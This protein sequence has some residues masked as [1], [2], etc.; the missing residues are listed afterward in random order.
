VEF[1]EVVQLLL[2][3]SERHR[4]A[5]RAVEEFCRWVDWQG[6]SV[7]GIPRS[8][9]ETSFWEQSIVLRSEVPPWRPHVATSLRF[10]VRDD[11]DGPSGTYHLLSGPGG[12]MIGERV[13]LDGE[14]PFE[15]I[16]PGAWAFY[17]GHH[18]YCGPIPRCGPGTRTASRSDN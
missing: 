3:E 6:G 8:A 7:G 1:A 4:L 9:F 2:S 12:E 13:I 18:A 11:D 10:T 17:A 5:E 14:L 16:G 15:A